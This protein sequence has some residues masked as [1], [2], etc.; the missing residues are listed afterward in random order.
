MFFD[1]FPQGPVR[2]PNVGTC[3]V[4]MCTLILVDDSCLVVFG[5]LVF[6]VAQG[7]PEGVGPF[8]VDLNTSSFA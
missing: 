1:S 7:C 6:G 4:D 5:I 8:E 2:F 3:A